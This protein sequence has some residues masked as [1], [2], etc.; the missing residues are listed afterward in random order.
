[1]AL[2]CIGKAGNGQ[3]S[4]PSVSVDETDGSFVFVGD[5]VKDPGVIRLFGRRAG[6][7]IQILTG[8]FG[9]ARHSVVWERGI[10]HSRYRP[11]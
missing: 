10:D 6:V 2:R 9:K 8:L 1:M 4:C 3:G 5:P 11:A 7:M